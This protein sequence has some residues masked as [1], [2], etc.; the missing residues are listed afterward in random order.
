MT[1]L[2]RRK[3][4]PMG[5]RESV[6]IRS[7]GH[8]AWVRGFEC[9]V[10]NRRAAHECF[11]RSEAAHVRTGTDGGTGLKPGD[12]WVIPLCSEAHREQHQIGEAAFERLYGIDM[13]AIA[14]A[15]WKRS[16]HRPRPV[17]T[18]SPGPAR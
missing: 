11:G 3:P 2:K 7:P 5:T 13:K 4:E 15:L 12:N 14:S 6:Q 17:P 18:R 10:I 8:L 9:S 16:P 1:F